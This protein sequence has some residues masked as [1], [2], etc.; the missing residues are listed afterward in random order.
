MGTPLSRVASGPAAALLL[1]RALAATVGPTFSYA[2]ASATLPGPLPDCRTASMHQVVL[3][4]K[5]PPATIGM[6][7]PSAVLKKFDSLMDARRFPEARCLCAGRMLRM[8]DFMALTQSKIAD[9]VD[10]GRSRDTVLE[11]KSAGDWAYAKIYSRMVFKRPFMGQDSLASVQAAHLYKS[12]RGWLIAEMEE[13]EGKDAPVKLRTGIPE[14]V[15]GRLSGKE[16]PSPGGKHGSDLFPVSSRAPQRPGQADRIRYRLQLKD[17]SALAGNCSLDGNQTLLRADSPSRWIVESRRIPNPLTPGP[18]QAKPAAEPALPPDSARIYLA[19]NAYLDLDDSLL[20][21]RAAAIAGAETGP[22]RVAQAV[23]AWVSG[24]F[25]FRMGS[26]LFGTSTEII[27]DLTGD[28]SEAAIL[29]AALMRARGV[30]ARVAL[31][32]ASL[33]QGVFI[34]HAWCEAWLGGC[35][36][37]VDAA[38]R[39]FPAGIERIKLATLDGRGDMRIAA[40]NLMMRNISNLEIEI[41]GAWEKDR[42][43]PLKEYPDNSAQAERFF[44]E[45]MEGI[46][47]GGKPD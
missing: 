36:V 1:L 14:G 32:F 22:V 47:K 41:L 40:T 43:L 30:P 6:A 46:G 39:E 42:G 23:Y 38:L 27:R 21:R 25:R 15:D 10:T 35:W 18:A 33:G 5:S 3:S 19:S 20:T 2:A 31:G 45:I 12:P 34:G 9:Y 8:F 13:L 44:K 29:T 26:V 4:S 37:G 28:C 24:H 16:D 11:E 17:G 7:G